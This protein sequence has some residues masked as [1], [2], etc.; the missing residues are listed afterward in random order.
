MPEGHGSA[1]LGEPSGVVSNCVPLLLEPS[2]RFQLKVAVLGNQSVGKTTMINSIFQDQFGSVSDRRCTAGVHHYHIEILPPQQEQPKTMIQSLTSVFL[3]AGKPEVR[4]AAQ[5]YDQVVATDKK[6]RRSM[7]CESVEECHWNVKCPEIVSTDSTIPNQGVDLVFVDIP[8]LNCPDKGDQYKRYVE[9]HFSEFDYFLVMVDGDKFSTSANEMGSPEQTTK[10]DD[11]MM[12]GSNGVPGLDSESTAAPWSHRT[13]S[14]STSHYGSAWAAT[15]AN[16]AAAAAQHHTGEQ[17]PPSRPVT[18]ELYQIGSAME[19]EGITNERWQATA[20][21][22]GGVEDDWSGAAAFASSGEHRDWTGY[23]NEHLTEKEQELSRGGRYASKRGGVTSPDD[24]DEL[25]ASLSSES[26][27]EA[28]SAARHYNRAPP[29]PSV[30]CSYL[31]EDDQKLV[32]W[33]AGLMYNQGQKLD[34]PPSCL[35]VNKVDLNKDTTDMQT[36]IKKIKT[37]KWFATEGEVAS[38]QHVFPISALGALGV[39]ISTSKNL[40]ETVTTVDTQ[41]VHMIAQTHLPMPYAQWLELKEDKRNSEVVQYLKKMTPEDRLEK[42]KKNKFFEFLQFLE[43]AIGKRAQKPLLIRMIKRQ[44]NRVAVDGLVFGDL[45]RF[46]ARSRQLCDGVDIGT[47][48]QEIFHKAGANALQLFKLLPTAE[49]VEKLHSQIFGL[50]DDYL[51]FADSN[52]NVQET[53]QCVCHIEQAEKRCADFLDDFLHILCYRATS[54]NYGF[55]PSARSGQAG[56]PTSSWRALQPENWACLIQLVSYELE[57]G[58]AFSSPG[59]T[60]FSSASSSTKSGSSP[61]SF[62][63]GGSSKITTA[64]AK[65]VDQSATSGF[66]NVVRSNPFLHTV[67][68]WR[69]FERASSARIESGL[70]S[71]RTRDAIRNM[72]VTEQCSAKDF[73]F[74]KMKSSMQD[75]ILGG[76]AKYVA[77]HD[78]FLSHAKDVKQRM[79]EL[80]AS[81]KLTNEYMFGASSPTITKRDFEED[82]DINMSGEPSMKRVRTM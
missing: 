25:S 3:G 70:T 40:R 22:P 72:A 58:R 32:K 33:F 69:C 11:V 67:S 59:I 38:F 60:A 74:T 61:I 23:G 63:A 52:F 13:A 4:P 66:G 78:R 71:S 6:L 77:L 53:D 51:K 37:A 62:T 27:A 7:G 57:V 45:V 14:D 64:T 55:S 17:W 30:D 1:S 34:I 19:S 42:L 24:D 54:H 80:Q 35:V 50:L 56:P 18:Q 82:E 47:R 73:S 29:P 48:F 20:A 81:A 49:H 68:T 21:Y 43:T 31:G 76:I 28:R 12:D 15:N 41:C 16:L 10:G 8:G 44:M 75:P 36:S 2:A 26:P 9:N 39:R 5:V 46:H 65:A 79:R